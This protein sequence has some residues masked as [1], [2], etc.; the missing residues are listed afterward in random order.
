MSDHHPTPVE[1]VETA[2]SDCARY[3]RMMGAGLLVVA[4]LLIASLVL[5]RNLDRHVDN[6]EDE[7]TVLQE[8]N[9]EMR[10]VLVFVDR[11]LCDRLPNEAE[12]QQE[13]PNP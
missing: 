3:A 2:A 7:V 11:L 5:Y 1:R 10:R 13:E 8:D 4:V 9:A 6:L 12:C